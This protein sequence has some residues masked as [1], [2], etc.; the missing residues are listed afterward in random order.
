SFLFDFIHQIVQPII[1]SQG[2][3]KA[4]R[5]HLIRLNDAQTATHEFSAAELAMIQYCHFKGYSCQNAQGEN[6]DIKGILEKNSMEVDQS[7]PYAQ[8]FYQF[9][10][11]KNGQ[12]T[13]LKNKT[14]QEAEQ[15]T[16]QH[17]ASPHP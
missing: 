8:A 3:E 12:E 6:L 16:E 15:E 11:G 10:S 1:D 13:E 2:G 7:S 4:G 5:K 17:P 14:E 9:I